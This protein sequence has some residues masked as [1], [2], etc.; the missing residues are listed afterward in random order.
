MKA[1]LI[2]LA[3]GIIILLFF[4]FNSNVRADKSG[5]DIHVHDTYFNISYF[6][7][8]LFI[9]L[10]L[11]TFFC[12]GGAI[13]TA[14]KNRTFVYLLLACVLLVSYYIRILNFNLPYVPHP[15]SDPF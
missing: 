11:G 15:N 14:F 3:I 13:G 7:F 5:V 12:L 10:F 9:A 1:A 8:T 6:Y 2:S 4:L